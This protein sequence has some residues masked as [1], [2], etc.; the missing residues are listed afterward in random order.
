MKTNTMI[1]NIIFRQSNNRWIDMDF[2]SADTLVTNFIRKTKQKTIRCDQ[3]KKNR[4]LI[5][6]S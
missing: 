6:S 1:Q 3:Q 4:T 5:F 2:E